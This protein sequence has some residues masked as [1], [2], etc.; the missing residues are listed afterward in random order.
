MITPEQAAAKPLPMPDAD[1]AE[2]WAGLARG[3][4]LLQ[5]CLS[6]SAI[7]YYQQ[8]MCR[9]CGSSHLEHRAA[10]GRGTVHSFSV[11]HRAP[12]P[13]FKDETPY[14]VLL[15]ELEEGPRMI[16]RLVAGADPSVVDFDMTVQLVCVPVDEGV[17]L[18]CFR[19]A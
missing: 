14:A 7:H 10:S 9:I 16:S 19:P 4:L 13:A 17:T 6:C 8:G 1:T 2:F 3:E 12:G 11:V 15:V 5:H 18:P